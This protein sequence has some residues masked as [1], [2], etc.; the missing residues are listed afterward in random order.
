MAQPTKFD[1]VNAVYTAP[2]GR[3]DVGDLFVMNNNTMLVSCWILD[4]VELDEVKQTGRVY[5]SVDGQALPPVFVGSES[6]VRD[7]TANFGQLPQQDIGY[8]KFF[9]NELLAFAR[10]M[11]N[12]LQENAHKGHWRDRPDHCT[13]EQLFARLVDEVDELRAELMAIKRGKTDGRKIGR[14]CAD[15]ANFAMMIADVC[16]PIM[17]PKP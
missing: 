10:V 9:H 1:G 3:D 12:K 13:P 17:E 11:D 7:L 8:M 6:A 4:P 2:P 14:E 15:V 16:E 5:L